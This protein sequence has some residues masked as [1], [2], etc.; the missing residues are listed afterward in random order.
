MDWHPE[1]CSAPHHGLLIYQVSAWSD[2]NCKRTYAETKNYRCNYKLQRDV[3]QYDRFSNM[4]IKSDQ[5]QSNNYIQTTPTASY[6]EDT[7][8]ISKWL[9]Q[10]CKKSCAHKTSRVNIDEWTDAW[11]DG[12]MHAQVTLLKQVWQKVFKGTCILNIWHQKALIKFAKPKQL[13]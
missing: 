2:V 7:R 4:R 11:R 5:I 9:V 10:N 1:T 3:T 12:N 8:K 13:L 6:H